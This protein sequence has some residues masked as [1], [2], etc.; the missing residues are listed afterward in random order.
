MTA[1]TRSK[2]TRFRIQ[3]RMRKFAAWKATLSQF[4][5]TSSRSRL[6]VQER[7]REDEDERDD[8]AVDRHRLDHGEAD[9]QRARDRARGI[10]LAGDR[11]HGARDRSSFG[12]RGADRAE[13]DR[14]GGSEDAHEVDVHDV[15]SYGW[16]SE[17]AGCVATA[18]LA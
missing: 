7:V 15:I 2:R 10:R 5:L 4:T 16:I 12:E 9:E 18:A 17:L 1:F 3:A 8:E 13:R 11:V 14:H 6:Q